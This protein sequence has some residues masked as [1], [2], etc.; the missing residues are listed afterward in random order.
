MPINILMPALS[1]TMTEGTLARWLIAEGQAVA[2]G[3]P[4]A[5]IETDKASMEVEAVD[6]GV[7]GRIL[8]PEG[9]EGVAVNAVIGVLLSD[10]EED[11]DIAVSTEA[12]PPPA[13]APVSAGNDERV[14]ASPLARRMAAQ[15]GLDIA[16]I[17]GSGPHGRVVKADIEAAL[18]GVATTD[19]R[20]P[21]D[22]IAAD[23]TV[24]LSAMRRVIA[25]RMTESKSTVPHFYLSVDCE[26][27]ELLRVRAEINKRVTPTRIT[28]NDIVIRACALAL[29]AVPAANVSWAGDGSM[30]RHGA[31]DISVAVAIPGGLVTPIVRDAD[32]K[33]LVAIAEAMK[34]L[35]ERARQGKLA[36]EE[37]QGGTFSISNL[38]MYGI[39][40]F[41]AI[42]NPPQAAIL[43]V[44]AGE[45]RPVARDGQIAP[46][47]VMTCT[48]SV[49]HRVVDGA[50]GAELLGAIRNNLEYPPA[51]LA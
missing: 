49:D 45:Q 29:R 42:I 3:D 21:A 20:A 51:M 10:G 46:A 4:I 39:R 12:A 50:T 40:N 23:E 14:F 1:P 26:I 44:G 35:A 41:D 5:E 36:P 7:L 19:A 28:V 11:A 6:E 22:G 24:K 15:A 43:A 30:V 47:T 48:L 34:G 37:Y 9:T 27:D 32:R 38:G 31:V 8:V 2:A 17:D 16:A 33:G 18:G 13:S 25:E